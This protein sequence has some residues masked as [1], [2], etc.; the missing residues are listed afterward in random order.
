[1][2]SVYAHGFSY[3]TDQKNF[4]GADN[5]EESCSADGIIDN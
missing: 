2:S 3:A 4:H 5:K 1:M